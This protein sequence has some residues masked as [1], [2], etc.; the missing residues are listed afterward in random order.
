MLL[1]LAADTVVEP[2][3]SSLD[4]VVVT[5][6]SKA[7][8]VRESPLA[9]AVVTER[10]LDRSADNTVIDA[11]VGRVPGFA[12]V[13]TGPN[14]SKPFINGLGYNRVLTLYDG[15]RVETQ[16]WG[17]EH[18]VPVDDYII[19]GAEVIKGPASLL[20]GSDA[21]AGVLSLFPLLPKP[22]D[23][24]LHGRV[25][26]EY[27]SNNGLVG[28]SLGLWRAGEHWSW[29]LRG[30]ERIAR[31][32]GNP[33]D[34]RVYNTGFR[35][36]N[37]SALLG[38]ASRSGYSRLNFTFYDNHQGIPDGSRDSL[39]RKFTRQVYEMAGVN[40]LQPFVDDVRNRPLVSGAA[41]RSYAVPVLS[42]RIQD[43]RVYTDNEYR[44]G[45]GMVKGFL[46][47]EENIRREFNHPT[48]PTLAGEWLVLQTLNYG[49]RYNAPAVGN[50]ET[51][52]GINGMYQ[53]NRNGRATDF[54][55]PDHHVFDAGGYVFGKWKRDKWIVSGGVRYDHRQLHG[56]RMEVGVDP[57]TGFYGQVGEGVVGAKEQF[58]DFSL[59]F[60]GVTGSLGVC[61]A[62][63]ERLNLKA[64]IGR[65]YRSPNITEIAANG[66]D[67]GAHI[68]YQGNLGFKPEFSLQEDLALAGEYP[69]VSFEAGVFH[70]SIQGYIYEDQEVDGAGNPVVIVP[71]NRTFQ[72]QQTDALLYGGNL[73]LRIHPSGWRG[74]SLEELFSCV[75]G[76]N[77]RPLYA[78]S[79]SN[80]EY[81]PFIPPMRLL[82]SIGYAW[83]IVSVTAEVD[84]HAAQDRY[85]G[86][87]QTERRTPGYTL[88]HFSTHAE[89][90]KGWQVQATVN[91]VFDLAYQ[92]H[93]SR[94][95]YLEYYTA[96]PNG[97][98]G[99]YDM[100]RNICL[101]VI[102]TF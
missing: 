15:M 73:G 57:G 99:I 31:G 78:H 77:R 22:A 37:A 67:P 88:V 60:R 48:A 9:I 52:V 6:V 101:K 4:Q 34:G 81:L 79:G 66:L 23:G 1:G 75:Y 84:L 102:R 72:F 29:A 50:V 64:N 13:K 80:G 26:S 17:D 3:F 33:V 5:G 49:L 53:A 43:Y 20:Y 36:L 11:I 94:L 55:I 27:Q 71:G 65:G 47:W 63:T 19:G 30:S 58:T 24:Q 95:Q 44:L 39:S 32:Y 45:G 41:L 85:L 100:G 56:R 92:D 87:Y 59:A 16:Q 97:R 90:K 93:L 40:F 25:L 70:N 82:S 98:V 12:A 54:P 76:F 42:Q 89:L 28:N 35:V 10:Q 62:L 18:G 7:M 8:R 96:S 68:V 91:N 86:L 14:V 38:Y 21:I 69:D 46:G 2:K 51:T 83:K 61:Y 74:F